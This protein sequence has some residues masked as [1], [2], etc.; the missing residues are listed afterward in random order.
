MLKINISLGAVAGAVANGSE[1]DRWF[2][3]IKNGRIFL[4]SANF[5]SDDEIEKAVDMINANRDNYIPLPFLSHEEFLDEVDMYIRTLR[6]KPVLAK[7][8]EQAVSEKASKNHIMGLL[9]HE[10]GQKSDFTDFYSG[11]VQEKVMAWLDS[12]SI[13]L[14]E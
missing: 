8:L 5:Q 9:N 2:I 4:I 14:T 3:D 7:Y 10:P 13:K 1:T 6:D 12:M 11:R